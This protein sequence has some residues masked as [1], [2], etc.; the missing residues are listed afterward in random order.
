MAS[1][2]GTQAAY[3]EVPSAL[4]AGEPSAA[5]EKLTAE[6]EEK[7]AWNLRGAVEQIN[8]AAVDK[9]VSTELQ[10][11]NTEA[12]K[13]YRVA[14]LCVYMGKLPDWLPYLLATAEAQKPLVRFLIFHNDKDFRPPVADSNVEFH[15]S[16]SAY[17]AQRSKT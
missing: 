6:A 14:L 17:T 10:A 4:G 9:Q 16:V 12:A 1:S 2:E 13:S 11:R 5:D 3:A 15:E 7:A 8:K